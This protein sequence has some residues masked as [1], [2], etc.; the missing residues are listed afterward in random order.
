MHYT[1]NNIPSK[2]IAKLNHRD[3]QISIKTFEKTAVYN[4][5]YVIVPKMISHS[6]KSEGK[7][8][9]DEMLL[10][11]FTSVPEK[12]ET[13][14]GNMGINLKTYHERPR[15]IMG[16]NAISFDGATKVSIYLDSDQ[17]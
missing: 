6:P 8:W 16:N 14:S 15:T 3:K 10:E 17:I 4:A 1:R 5:K 11:I 9:A 13:D 2:G 7:K 12:T